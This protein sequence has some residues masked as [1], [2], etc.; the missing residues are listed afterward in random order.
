MAASEP[1]VPG[2]IGAYPQ[3]NHV[4]T[5]RARSFTGVRTPDVSFAREKARMSSMPPPL[6]P[7]PQ[8]PPSMHAQQPAPAAPKKSSGPMIAIIAAV[9]IFALGIYGLLS[10]RDKLK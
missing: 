5:I 7:T 4:A 9:V 6:P 8:G 3:P 1:T 10:V 2:A